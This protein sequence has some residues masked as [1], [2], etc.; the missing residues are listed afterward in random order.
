MVGGEG[1]E[2]RG[3]VS[4]LLTVALNPILAQRMLAHRLDSV[5]PK[6]P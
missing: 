5:K 6:R 3:A 4:V 2:N 1:R